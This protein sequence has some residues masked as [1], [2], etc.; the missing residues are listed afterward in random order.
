MRADTTAGDADAGTGA[1][2]QDRDMIDLR[3]PSR[4][5]RRRR[6]RHRHRRLRALDRRARHARDPA[7]DRPAVDRGAV[8]RRD[9]R[10][11]VA[12]GLRVPAG[13]PRHHRH[14][15]AVTVTLVARGLPV[16]LD[17][18]RR[19]D[20][21][22]RL[23]LPRQLHG[24]RRPRAGPA[25]DPADPGRG[26]RGDA[27]PP[28]RSQREGAGRQPRDVHRRA[29]RHPAARPVDQG[30][31]GDRGPLGRVRVGRRQVGDPRAARPGRLH[32]HP[33]LDRGQP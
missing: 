28:R 3:K 21:R 2:I 20:H 10:P 33:V 12:V 22:P 19:H 30:R 26:H 17:R 11:V 14:P 25:R 9:A 5:D 32:P 29:G 4:V 13:V 6:H 27:R 23:L 16:A 18:H 24:Q 7:T 8:R 31:R 1:R 15:V